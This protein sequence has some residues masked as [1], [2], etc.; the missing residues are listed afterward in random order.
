VK[1]KREEEKGQIAPDPGNV[2]VC[3]HVPLGKIAKFIRLT[4]PRV[5]S[6]ISGCYGAGTG[7]GWCIP[8]LEKVHEQL[9]ADPDSEPDIGLSASEYLSRRREYLRSI[10]AERMKDLR[11]E[12]SDAPDL[13]E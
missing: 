5:P 13:L 9:T 1:D 6:Q 4:K 2:C 12:L 10:S 3:F 7:C 8:F 11:E